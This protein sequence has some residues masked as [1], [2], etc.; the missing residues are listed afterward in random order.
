MY[1]AF[2]GLKERP[3]DLTTNPRFLFL[4]ARHREAL[5]NLQ[6]GITSHKGITL[7]LGEAGTGKSTLVRT[8]LD[9]QRSDDVKTIYLSNPTLTRPEFF[10]FMA[11]ELGLNGEIARSKTLLLRELNDLV[12]QR[13]RSGG[14]TALIIDEA[15]SLPPELLEEVRLLANVET[16]SEKLLPVVLI[17]QPELAER[18]NH[19]AWRQMKQRIGL[20]CSLEPLDLRET[21]AYITK[22][23][24]I[25]GGDSGAIFL[26]DAVIAVYERSGGIP[27]TINVICD[28]ALVSGFALDQRPVGPDIIQEVAK[29]FDLDGHVGR[30][31]A[32][33]PVARAAGT[34]LP[35]RPPPDE[36]DEPVVAAAAGAES[37]EYFSFFKRRRRFSFF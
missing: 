16:A 27:R 23:I 31:V 32:E 9:R 22:R 30:P 2:Y 34:A 7:L 20:R 33:R 15:Q 6:Y 1:E 17:G 13:H 26:R 25:A 29:D 5:S 18:L 37:R 14:T 19:P 10:E 36:V 21:A 3:F 28:N 12:L 4:T 24:R 11:F 8:V 35:M